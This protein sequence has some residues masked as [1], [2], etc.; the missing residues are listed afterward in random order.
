M[1]AMAHLQ[2]FGEMKIEEPNCALVLCENLCSP[3]FE[4]QLYYSRARKYFFFSTTLQK[5]LIRAHVGATLLR[6]FGSQ[7]YRRFLCDLEQ[8]LVAVAHE[9][10]F[11]RV[12]FSHISAVLHICIYVY[13][14][15][16]KKNYKKYTKILFSII[17]GDR[18]YCSKVSQK[19]EQRI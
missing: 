14:R 13:T 17:Y 1:F 2:F 11:F 15:N 5:T 12:S 8:V 3:I 18:K 6:K 4:N 16:F 7:L 9:P 19:Y 10:P